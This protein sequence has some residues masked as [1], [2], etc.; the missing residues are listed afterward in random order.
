MT[1][2]VYL[3]PRPHD[4]IFKFKLTECNCGSLKG[5]P[6]YLSTSGVKYLFLRLAPIIAV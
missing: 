4:F 5:I 3:Q 1:D 2:S 6:N